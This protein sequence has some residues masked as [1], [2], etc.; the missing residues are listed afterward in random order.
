MHSS[1]IHKSAQGHHMQSTELEKLRAT[2]DAYF[3]HVIADYGFNFVVGDSGSGGMYLLQILASPQMQLKFVKE[4]DHIGISLGA[5]GAARL[6]RDDLNGERQWYLAASL[7]LYEDQRSPGQV[8]RVPPRGL[9]HRPATDVFLAD[10]A[11]LLQAYL[12]RLLPV[13]SA[14]PPQGWWEGFHAFE[15]AE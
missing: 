4:M 9:D 10:W 13:F 3:V 2:I 1:T 5:P 8:F 11:L 12:P 15:V 6:W 14:D 7:I